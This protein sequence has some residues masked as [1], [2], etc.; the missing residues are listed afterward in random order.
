M[1]RLLHVTH[2]MPRILGW[3]LRVLANFCTPIL[4]ISRPTHTLLRKMIQSLYFNLLYERHK[5]NINIIK[6]YSSKNKTKRPKFC[7]HA[8][9]KPLP[10]GQNS[11]LINTC[12]S[13]IKTFVKYSSSYPTETPRGTS[14][15]IA[16]SGFERQSPTSESNFPTRILK[17]NAHVHLGTKTNI[18]GTCSFP[19]KRVMKLEKSSF[20]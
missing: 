16:I 3:F 12:L 9:N 13:Q 18:Q 4:D 14:L 17:H 5:C 11:V 1:W 10:C 19:K 2:L 8:E 15:H 7:E 20:S 6:L